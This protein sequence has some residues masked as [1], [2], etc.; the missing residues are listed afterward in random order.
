M[1][2]TNTMFPGEL[3][4]ISSPAHF[5]YLCLSPSYLHPPALVPTSP[6]V[7]TLTIIP[8]RASSA[9]AGFSGTSYAVIKNKSNQHLIK[10]VLERRRSEPAEKLK[11]GQIEGM[12]W[13]ERWEVEGG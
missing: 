7:I 4:V 12:V 2:L 8:S 13:W 11:N 3:G 10:K 9:T 6:L 5:R 1:W